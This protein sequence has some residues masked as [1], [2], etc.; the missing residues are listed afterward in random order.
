MARIQILKL[1][2]EGHPFAVIIDQVNPT[3]PTVDMFHEANAAQLLG[4]RAVIMFEEAVE[5]IGQG[6]VPAAPAA[7]VIICQ[8]CE[9]DCNGSFESQGGGIFT[10][11]HCTLSPQGSL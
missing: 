7:K 2:G 4:A 3:S 6:S 11:M 9:R 8:F 5:I 10:C 1:P